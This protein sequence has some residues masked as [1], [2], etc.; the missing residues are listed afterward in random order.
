MT[1]HG[2]SY[3]RLYTTWE[4]MIGRCKS[5]KGK[6]WKNYGSRGVTVCNEWCDFL[7]FKKWALNNGYDVGLTLERKDGNRGYCPSNCKWAT[8]KEQANNTR[9]NH[10]ITYNGETKNFA[11]WSTILGL[12]RNTLVKRLSSGWSVEKALTEPVNMRYSH[13]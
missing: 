13:T 2:E 6:A 11:E 4:S 8:Y 9:Q 3:T 10:H 5:K 1:T 12:N 7:T